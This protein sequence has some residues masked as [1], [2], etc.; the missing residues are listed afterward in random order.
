MQRSTPAR[1]D[2]TTGV[3]WKRL[4]LFALPLLVSTVVQQLY[5]TV[6]LI[7]A[8]N[9]IDSDAAAAIGTSSL[10]ATCLVGFFGGMSVGAGVVISRYFGRKD[11]KRLS[12]AI[13]GTVALC[14]VGG[15]AL[16]ILG[17]L[18]APFYLTAMRTPQS[19]TASANGYLYIY[20]LSMSAIIFYNL[21]AGILRS[22]GD[23]RSTLYAQAIGGCANVLFDWLFIRVFSAYRCTF[24]APDNGYHTFKC[25]GTVS[26]QFSG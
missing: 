13:H 6:D 12:A 21:C 24:W 4:V 15:V 11:L 14:V 5:N 17:E 26:H 18:L 22:L 8:G 16:A 10:L 7:F 20:F 2:L 19:L 3:I 25:G 9:F 23:S 1:G